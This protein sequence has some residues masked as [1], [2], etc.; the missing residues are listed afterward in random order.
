M[1]CAIVYGSRTGNTEM[2]AKEINKII[3]KEDCAYFGQ[4]CDDALKSELI[5][6]G[7]WTNKE[8][9]DETVAGFCKILME[10]INLNGTVFP[11]RFSFRKSF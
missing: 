2:L 3:P 8:N 4:P 10:N 7:F 9:C 5:F 11:C 6:V 1:K